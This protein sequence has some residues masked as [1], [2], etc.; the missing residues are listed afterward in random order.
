MTESG[1][2]VKGIDNLLIRLS[3][4]CNPVPGDEIVGFITKGEVFRFIVQIVQIL[5]DEEDDSERIIDVEWA[6]GSAES[7]K[8]SKW[9]LK[10]TAFDR[11]GVVKR[12]DDGGCGN[13][14]TDCCG[15]RQSGS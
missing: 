6:L 12:S 14:D 15:K 2:I 4:C 9:I 1:V 7:E 13:E 3:K 8:N 11:Q 5:C 10:C